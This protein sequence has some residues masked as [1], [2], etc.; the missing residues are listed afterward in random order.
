M[1]R[2]LAAAQESGDLTYAAFVCYDMISQ[3]LASGDALDEVQR[4]AE[5]ALEF[6]L[7]SRFGL[8]ADSI[9]GQLSLIRTLR[10]LTPKFGLFNDGVFNESPLRTTP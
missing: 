4:E 5:S 10:G 2:A 3:L 7:K 6:V 9:T 8:I 1:R